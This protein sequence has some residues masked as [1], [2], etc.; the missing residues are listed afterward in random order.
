[1]RDGV[2]PA[3]NAARARDA[4]LRPRRRQ[5]RCADRLPEAPRPAVRCR[6]SRTRRCGSARCC[7]PSAPADD[8]GSAVQRVLQGYLDGVNQRGG[9]HGRKLQLVVEPAGDDDASARAALDRLL[10]K[11]PVLALLAP[12]TARHERAFAAAAEQARVP[13]VG[14]LTLFPEGAAASST[15]VFH[16]LPGVP[17]AGRGARR[18]PASRA[19]TERPADRAAARGGRGRQGDRAGRRGAPEGPRVHRPLPRA[20]GRAA[21]TWP[22]A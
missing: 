2:D 5:P 8:A 9:V 6:A 12:M 7:R 17:G 11:D 21:R 20:G 3:G 16:V 15:Y 18:P 14:P 1:M 4:A 19:G 13:L 22:R 10:V